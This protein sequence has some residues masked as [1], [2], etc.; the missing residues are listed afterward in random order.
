LSTRILGMAATYQEAAYGRRREREVWQAKEGALTAGDVL[1]VMSD[2]KVRLRDNF[3][4]GKGQRANIR[5]V[6][7]D[8]MY[9]PSRTSFKDSHVD[10]IQRLHKEKEK[11][12]LTNVIGHADR[13]KAL[14]ALVRR[15]S[16]SVR[17]NYREDV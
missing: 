2:L 6:C 7:A 13:E 14:A 8:E 9:K 10:A 4:F 15:T 17:N 12:E 16:S 1:G 11:H 5:A 3:T